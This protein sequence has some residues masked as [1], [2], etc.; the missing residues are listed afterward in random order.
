[1]R[2]DVLQAAALCCFGNAYLSNSETEKAPELLGQNS[3][4]KQVYELAFVRKR[5]LAL[6]PEPESTAAW[7]RQLKAEGVDR[8]FLYLDQ[9]SYDSK[10]QGLD[11]WGVIADGDRGCE[12][13]TP[14]WKARSMGK[15]DATPYRVIYTSDRFNRWSLT[16]L[17]PLCDAHEKMT[18]ALTLARQFA[19]SQHMMQLLPP[20]D[21]CIEL[22]KQGNLDLIGC[23][24]L[25]PD[26]YPE[27]GRVL[28]ASVLRMQLIVGSH[29][30][31][32][33]DKDPAI[34]AE[35]SV[36]TQRLWHAGMVCLTSATALGSIPMELP[37]ALRAHLSEAS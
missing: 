9:C 7:L 15:E 17:A 2:S 13:W 32:I 20:I 37:T 19:F 11:P 27:A 1:M 33:N 28:L 14:G 8:L 4:F 24:D 10:K 30:W 36:N 12:L 6:A 26:G 29:L 3:T 34:Q 23:G 18:K 31:A 25:C 35:F 22:H 5:S 21:R 16:P